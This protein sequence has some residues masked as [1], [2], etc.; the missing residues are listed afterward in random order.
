MR[1]GASSF[2]YAVERDRAVIMFEAHN[3]RI[4]FLLPMPDRDDREFAHTPAKRQARSPQQAEAA[5]EQA[6]RQRWRALALAIKAKLE[7]VEVGITSFEDEFLAHVMLPDGTTFGE[8]ANPQ[9]DR[10]YEL[11]EMPALMPGGDR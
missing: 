3:R 2:A 6:V 7:A 10:A 1:Y 9:I 8:W 5:Y 11:N 4:R